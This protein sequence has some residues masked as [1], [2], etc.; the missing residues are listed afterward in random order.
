MAPELTTAAKSEPWFHGGG[1]GWETL[2]NWPN[3]Q[4]SREGIWLWALGPATI[5]KLHA[6][7]M[8][9]ELLPAPGEAQHL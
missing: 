7:P 3:V 9:E 6:D 8:P 1:K 5:S 2:G 4:L